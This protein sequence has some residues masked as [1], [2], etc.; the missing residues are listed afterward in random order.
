MVEKKARRRLLACLFLR[1][2]DKPK[3]KRFLSPSLSPFRTMSTK[4]KKP[5]PQIP[6][7]RLGLLVERQAPGPKQFFFSVVVVVFP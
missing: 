5:N 1:R 3:K 6:S 2:R 7:S 4:N